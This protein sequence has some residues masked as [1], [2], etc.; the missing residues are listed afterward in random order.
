MYRLYPKEN[1][2]RLPL[3][4]LV[5]VD[6]FGEGFPIAFCLST[7]EDVEMMKTLVNKVQDNIDSF[8]DTEWFMSDATEQFY[9]A[10]TSV[11][12][13]RQVLERGAPQKGPQCRD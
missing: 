7:R 12:K 10:Y 2:I 6:E 1:R 9:A 11:N 5:V 13:L 8:M 4:T 3:T